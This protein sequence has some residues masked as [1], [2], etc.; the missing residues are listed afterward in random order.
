[1]GNVI[2]AK[3]RS[4]GF[5]NQF[6]YGGNKANYRTYCAVP[7]INAET[8][9]FENVNF[10]EEKDNLKYLF[11]TDKFLKGDNL[12]RSTIRNFDLELNEVNNYCP[13]CKQYTFDFHLK[14]LTD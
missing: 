13:N 6:N 5:N 3:C 14:Y 1:M 11:Y 4:C 8:L 7:A 2:S 10:Y 12:T 9:T